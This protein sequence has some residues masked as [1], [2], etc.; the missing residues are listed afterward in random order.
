MQ[1]DVDAQFLFQIKYG[2]V[3][4]EDR[5]GADL[6]QVEQIFAQGGKFFLADEIVQCD[7]ELDAVLVRK[8]DG[9]FQHFVVEIRIAVVHAHV[10]VLAAQIDGIRAR[11]DGG[12]EGIPGASRCE[13]LHAITG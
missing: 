13:K 6:L 2:E 12:D 9:F 3:L 5:V 8:V 4:H 10:E 11:L 7:I 1:R